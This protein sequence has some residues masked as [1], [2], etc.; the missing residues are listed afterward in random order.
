MKYRSLAKGMGEA[1]AKRTI[2]RTKED[3]SLETWG[4]V[5][6]KAPFFQADEDPF[7]IKSNQVGNYDNPIGA[8]VCGADMAGTAHDSNYASGV[9][10]MQPTLSVA[11][12]KPVFLRR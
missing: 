5:A 6:D 11:E 4:D 7:I 2:L 10:T 3:K 12:T 1:V 9:R 8:I